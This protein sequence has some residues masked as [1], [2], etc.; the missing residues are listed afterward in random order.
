MNCRLCGQPKKGPGK[1]CVDC[2]A[3][4]RRARK[5]AIAAASPP[6]PPA[7]GDVATI[8]Q[9]VLPPRPVPPASR[10][11]SR[12]V[13]AWV[14]CGV[15]VAASVYL[16]WN[17][18]DS[19]PTGVADDAPTRPVAARPDVETVS[20]PP[21][22]AS[23][24]LDT[25]WSTAGPTPPYSAPQVSGS[26]ANA[27]GSGKKP[28]TRAATLNTGPAAAPSPRKAADAVA[29]VIPDP[30]PPPP[31]QPPVML[32]HAGALQPIESSERWKALAAAVA[33]CA[34]EGFLGG[35][36]CEQKV[37]LRYCD[38]AWEKVPQCSRP[39]PEQH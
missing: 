18:L 16:G 14:A 32:A 28:D 22:A 38:G 3:S 4:L 11:A 27:H 29:P 24:Q 36:I 7:A 20:V 35:V 12:R 33:K 17:L 13:V 5:G 1:L 34:E 30:L 8:E 21:S 23:V 26:P 19:R 39:Q 9:Q 6:A 10:V 37:R 25:P 31:E 15:G 2:E